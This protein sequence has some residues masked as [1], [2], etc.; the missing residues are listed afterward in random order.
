MNTKQEQT[1][2]DIKKVVVEISAC[3]CQGRGSACGPGSFYLDLTLR[4]GLGVRSFCVCI[5]FF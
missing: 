1:N 4:Q 5:L 2:D 3:E